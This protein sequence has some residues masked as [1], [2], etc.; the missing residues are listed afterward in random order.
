MSKKKI[1]SEQY[2]NRKKLLHPIGSV[3]TQKEIDFIKASK[4]PSR[5]LAS[6]FNVSH[7][8]IANVRKFNY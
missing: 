4:A 7:V 3:L 2:E 8:T 6:V 5:K 1:T